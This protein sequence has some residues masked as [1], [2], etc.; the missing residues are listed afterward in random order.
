M[1]MRLQVLI[2]EAELE[3]IRRAAERSDMTV[4]EWVRRS[5]REARRKEPRKSARQKLDAIRRATRHSFPTAD[6]DRM[7]EEISRGHVTDAEP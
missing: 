4:S 2:D 7:L 6:I 1:S 3:E 5:L